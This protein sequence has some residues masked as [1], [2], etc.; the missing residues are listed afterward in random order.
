MEIP[1]ATLA[2]H[3][4]DSTHIADDVVTAS[5]AYKKIKV[6]ASGF[7]GAEPDEFRWNIDYGPIDSWST[8]LWY[9]PT[10]NWATQVSLGHLAHPEAMEPGD[11]TRSTAS[12]EYS[13][14][15]A[16]ESWSSTLIWGRD[17]STYTRRNTNSYTLESALPVRKKNWVTGR[18]ELVDKDELFAGE[19]MQTVI[20]DRFGS[21][22]RI[23]A[24]TLGYT[25]DVSIFSKLQTGIGANFETYSL[26]QPIKTFYG[27][28]PIG[29]NVCVRLRLNGG[30]GK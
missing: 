29:G 6:E 14:R 27:D 22:F 8:R 5:L 11:Q 30:S 12:V 15:L 2:H 3:W 25:R 28:H 1:Q 23:G 18:A 16:G 13:R 7:H 24:Y 20:D 10:K 26:P 19:T 4:Q 17:H 21:T 9:F